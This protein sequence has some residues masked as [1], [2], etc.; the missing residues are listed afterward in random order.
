LLERFLDAL[1]TENQAALLQLFAADATWTSDG[2]GK[3]KAALKVVHS[4]ELVA[5]F[6][7]GIWR[8][9]LK[10]LTY[11]LTTVNGEAGLVAFADGRPSW[12]F[13]IDTDGQRILAAYS[14]VNP[15]KLEGIPPLQAMD[16]PDRS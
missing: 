1:R 5:R 3:A 15:D 16:A 9:Y 11:R 12:V 14:V 7:R 4:A 8:R 10:N 6:T 2:G 13:T